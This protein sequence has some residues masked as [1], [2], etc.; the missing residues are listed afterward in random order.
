MCD[1]KDGISQGLG[2]YR[3][4]I[5][6]KLFGRENKLQCTV[7]SQSR[8]A[9]TQSQRK[10]YKDATIPSTDNATATPKVCG[11]ECNLCD[12]PVGAL[13]VASI[14]PVKLAEAHSW[15]FR[16]YECVSRDEAQDESEPIGF[17]TEWRN[18]EE[19]S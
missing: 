15:T 17:T 5:I 2:S 14:G 11:R 4:I 3:Y 8:I 10:V 19:H 6:V 16:K 7:K 12:P 18:V 13:V 9:H 1:N